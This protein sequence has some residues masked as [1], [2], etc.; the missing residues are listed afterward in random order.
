MNEVIDISNALREDGNRDA[1]RSRAAQALR[2]RRVLD[3][4]AAEL[5][6]N[7]DRIG[8]GFRSCPNIEIEK[9]ALALYAALASVRSVLSHYIDLW[10]AAETEC[11]LSLEKE[12]KP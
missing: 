9:Q 4:M 11:I 8:L 3:T 5:E 10:I 1:L 12:N 7:R 2:L 6:Q